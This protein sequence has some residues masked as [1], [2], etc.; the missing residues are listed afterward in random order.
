MKQSMEIFFGILT[1]CLIVAGLL[2]QLYF[3]IQMILIARVHVE[4]ILRASAF[5]T[6]LLIFFGA[7]SLGVSIAE[8]T[9]SAAS[10]SHPLTFGFF[11]ILTPSAIGVMLSWYF[12]NS[13]NRSSNIVIRAMILVGTFSI[14]QFADVYLRAVSDSTQ[15]KPDKSLVP[16]LAFIISIMLYAILRYD[17][18]DAPTPVR[19]RDLFRRLRFWKPNGGANYYYYTTGG[20]EAGPFTLAEIRRHQN[21]GTIDGDTFIFK[22]GDREWRPLSHFVELCG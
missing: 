5:S 6:G 7:K 9:A 19:V 2:T 3:M 4:R 13:L 15:L 1:H 14:I 12:V 18:D 16:N 20:V 10:L 21:N 8:L 17:P 22:E 11:G